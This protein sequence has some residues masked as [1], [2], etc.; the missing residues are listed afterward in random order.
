[1]TCYYCFTSLQLRT[2]FHTNLH[3]VLTQLTYFKA[4]NSPDDDI[5]HQ[6]IPRQAHHEHHGVHRDYDGNDG[7]H[8]LR[9]GVPG[10][11]GRVVED[12]R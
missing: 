6:A 10:A 5:H 4:E 3:R 12:V 1:M 2:L 9:F 11:V 7:R 8:R